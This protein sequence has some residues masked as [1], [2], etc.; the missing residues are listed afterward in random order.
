M[1]ITFRQL[2]IFQSVAK[3]VNFTRAAEEL[4]LSQP[5]V[6]MQIKQLENTVGVPLYEQLG[7]KIYLTQAGEVLFRLS[8]NIQKQIIE[9]EKE[10]DDLK[11]IEGGLL[12]IS[13]ATTVNYYAARLLSLFFQQYPRVRINLDVTNRA[14]LLEKLEANETDLVLMGSVPEDLDLVVEPFMDNPLVIIAPPNHP[15]IDEKNIPLNKLKD[16]TLLMREIGSGTRIA[17]EMFFLEKKNFKLISTIEMNSNEAIKQ[18]VEAGLGLG[19]VSQHTIE[20]EKEVGRLK[21]LDVNLFPIVEQWNIV[22]RKGKRRSAAADSFRQF[23]FANENID[24]KN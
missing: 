4:C 21:V 12:K 15:L 23:I 5:A 2:Q 20:L 3:H 24:Y 6:S 10:L 7:K 14:T 17:M 16:D 19:I 11:G 13:V 22:H 8:T 9:A 18:S 1:N